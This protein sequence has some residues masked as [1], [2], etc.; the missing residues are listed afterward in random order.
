M[1]PAKADTLLL[2]ALDEPYTCK[3]C[4]NTH[5]A[6]FEY[7]PE[8][9]AEPDTNTPASPPMI[10]CCRCGAPTWQ[11][12]TRAEQADHDEDQRGHDEAGRYGR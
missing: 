2:L 7:E 4:G 6:D 11:G 10:Y 12:P 9:R 8:H 1:N 3:V 5:Q